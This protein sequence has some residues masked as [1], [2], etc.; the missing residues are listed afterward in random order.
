MSKASNIVRTTLSALSHKAPSWASSAIRSGASF[1]HQSHS[2]SPWS[3]FSHSLAYSTSSKHG[4]GA[5]NAVLPQQAQQSPHQAIIDR[6]C[7]AL[8]ESNLEAIKKIWSDHL[9]DYVLKHRLLYGFPWDK[10]INAPAW[11]E[12][13]GQFSVFIQ[14]NP[15]IEQEIQQAQSHEFASNPHAK[16]QMVAQWQ[17]A[18]EKSNFH[19]LYWIWQET[20]NF[21]EQRYTLLLSTPKMDYPYPS[22]QFEMSVDMHQG[23]EKIFTLL[24]E[25]CLEWKEFCMNP[26]AHN[27]LQN[28]F[29]AKQSDTT[30]DPFASTIQA[31]Y[32]AIGEEN[33]ALM[34]LIHHT[35]CATG[36]PVLQ[37]RLLRGFPK[38]SY[39]ED[40]VFKMPNAKS[41]VHMANYIE[42]LRKEFHSTLDTHP[43]QAAIWKSIK[44]AMSQ[45]Q[46]TPCP[47]QEGDRIVGQWHQAI[48]TLD[49]TTMQ[50]ILDDA[51]M[52]SATRKSG[53]ILQ[54]RLLEG[55]PWDECIQDMT[56]K[57]RSP[58]SKDA[59]KKDAVLEFLMKE[60][61][62]WYTKFYLVD[63]NI[64][65]EIASAQARDYQTLK[66]QFQ[67]LDLWNTAITENNDFAVNRLLGKT[68]H[69]PD[70]QRALLQR[71]PEQLGEKVT[72]LAVYAKNV[73]EREGSSSK[74]PLR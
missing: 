50:N 24:Q 48:K 17:D 27:Q 51:K 58:L 41:R 74:T 63:P 29:G 23:R 28:L 47:D 71:I 11:S 30:T 15:A 5:F 38:E 32:Q 9:N 3:T 2:S 16:T 7:Q 68:L 25:Q 6:W 22:Y 40:V 8:E 61:D 20:R 1:P 67:M 31:W 43:N 44:Q 39:I 42:D 26:K 62:Q 4:V 53:H 36:S 55:F 60:R 46:L 72:W 10:T 45:H 54:Y 33:Y 64:R 35:V 66:N 57:M 65:Q 12:L 34:D 69:F 13:S 21:P 73:S 70:Q 14:Q 37:Y 49:L 19:A 59:V 52:D 56:I 18:I